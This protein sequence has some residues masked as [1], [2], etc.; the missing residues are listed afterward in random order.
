MV[1]E[2]ELTPGVREASLERVTH[3]LAWCWLKK[4]PS[5]GV[6]LSV[7]LRQGWGKNP[8]CK[9]L[10][11]E[12]VVSFVS[13]HCSF[14]KCGCGTPYLTTPELYCW[15]MLADR[16]VEPRGKETESKKVG[17]GCDSLVR[18]VSPG[19]MKGISAEK[20]CGWLSQPT[21]FPCQV[22]TFCLFSGFSGWW[23]GVRHVW[24]WAVAL[25]LSRHVFQVSYFSYLWSEDN[26]SILTRVFWGLITKGDRHSINGIFPFFLLLSPPHW[27]PSF[28]LLSLTW[29]HLPLSYTVPL[30][31][32]YC[33]DISFSWDFSWIFLYCIL[34]K[35]YNQL[36]GFND[37]IRILCF[38]S[39]VIW[40]VEKQIVSVFEALRR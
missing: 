20:L 35:H 5:D 28:C 17:G 23:P 2:T 26:I 33:G 11:S 31:N 29:L 21:P 24:I 6:I 7:K 19:D 40:W 1:L 36:E 34:H 10:R 9:G 38:G 15:H 32:I 8:G 27:S 22:L 4:A 39:L 13:T 3:D 14:E 16:Y 12:W 18:T 30:K 25:T 37:G